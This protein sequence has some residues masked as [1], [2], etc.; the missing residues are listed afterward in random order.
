MASSWVSLFTYRHVGIR[1]CE[2]LCVFEGLDLTLSWTTT[3]KATIFEFF[4]FHYSVILEKISFHIVYVNDE[5]QIRSPSPVP[6]PASNPTLSNPT[7][8]PII[9]PPKQMDTNPGDYDFLQVLT[10]EGI[11]EYFQTLWQSYKTRTEPY[12]QCLIKW[13]HDEDFSASFG[14]ITMKFLSNGKAMVWFHLEEGYLTP[15]SFI[16][17]FTGKKCQFMDWSIAFEVDINIVEHDVVV[18]KS[19]S[20]FERFQESFAWKQ[21]GNQASRT[22]NHL[23]LDFSSTFFCLF[24][25]CFRAD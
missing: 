2:P 21:H 9:H 11:V 14:A 24:L 13:S 15:Q 6:D 25:A 16:S 12:A 23:C 19:G 8:L 1:V 3:L 18:K 17:K 22:L 10:V 20:W 4:Q 7:G 5:K